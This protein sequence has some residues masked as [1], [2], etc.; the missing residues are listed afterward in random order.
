MDD[1]ELV[2]QLRLPWFTNGRS[3]TTQR[4]TND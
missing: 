4:R 3:N 1:A 2:R